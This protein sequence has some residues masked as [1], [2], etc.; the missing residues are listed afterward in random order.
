MVIDH[1]ATADTR[2]RTGGSVPCTIIAGSTMLHVPNPT[3]LTLDLDYLRTVLV[4]LLDIPSPSGRTD[5]IM[6]Y[7]GERL[8]K[9]GLDVV[10]TRRG[11]IVSPLS[12]DMGN[13][14]RAI[15]VHADTIGTIV[16]GL[17]DNGRLALTPVGSHSARFAEGASVRVFTDVLDRV[18]SG[19]VL[20]LKASG[21]RYDDAVD[22]QGV[23]WEHVEVRLDEPVA[24]AEDLRELG[25]DV[26]DFV[27]LLTEPVVTESGYIR[28]RHLDDKA[29]LAAT[30]TAVKALLDAQITLPVPAHLLVT[31]TEELGHGA[32]HGLDESIAEIVS[33]DVA[34]VAPGQQSREEAVTVAMGDSVGPFDYHLSR[35]LA[36]LGTDHG[37][38]V[39]RDVFDFY[40]SDVAAAVE[41]GAHARVALLGFGVDA[42]HGHERTHV[43][44]LINLTQLLCLYLQSDL[45]FPDWDA[46]PEGELADFPSLAVQPA[47]PDGPQ[48]G[49]IGIE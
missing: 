43:D 11:A 16:R 5:H 21:H 1:G 34:V 49:P 7:V 24:S 41:A 8:R 14:E 10:L 33:V 4:E 45:V 47:G 36:S 3:P 40:R 29:G 48:E 17:K 31:C 6:Q 35:R 15:V 27:A 12:G 22:S 26:G 9:L 28:S 42:T 46:E 30:L 2:R 39:V 13:A 20:P 37:L 38:D 25:I 32:S 44:S 19:Q 18:F 23:G